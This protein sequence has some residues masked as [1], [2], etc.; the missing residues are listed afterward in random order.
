MKNDYIR[1]KYENNQIWRRQPF[2]RTYLLRLL[3]FSLILGALPTLF[4]G[5]ASY[6]IATRGMEEKVNEGSMHLLLQT[7]LR[8]EQML[9]SLE[10]STT[11]FVNSSLLKSTLDRALTSQDFIQVRGLQAELT[12]LQSTAVVKQAHLVNFS[13]DWVLN[14]LALK[15]LSTSEEAD[16]FRTYAGQS[17]G[18]AWNTRIR[19]ATDT[20][21]AGEAGADL[22][23]A[24]VETISLIYKIPLIPPG[25]PSKALLVVQISSND[26]RSVLTHSETLGVHYIL[27]PAG[28]PFLSSRSDAEAYRNINSAI[29]RRVQELGQA[30]GF[31]YAEVNDRKV[32]VMYRTSGYNGWT[33]VSVVSHEAITR[34]TKTIG[35]FTA[36]VCGVILLIVLVLAYFG[37]RKMYSPIRSLLVY[38]EEIGEDGEPERGR[39]DELAFIKQRIES[40]AVSKTNLK[41]LMQGQA[42]SLK[43]FCVLKLF[44]GQMSDNEFAFRTASY[45]FPTEWNQLGVLT[46]QIDSLRNTRYKGQDRELLLFAINNIVDELLPAQTRFSPILL[47]E[48]QITLL[49]S[50]TEDVQELRS[51]FYRTAEQIK[52]TVEQ[53]LQLTVSI[54]ISRPFT[55]LSESP[56]AYGECLE[57]LK[58]RISLGP[59]IIVHYEDS[60]SKGTGETVVYSHLKLIEE[61]IIQSLREVHLQRVNGLF[62]QYLDAVLNKE[63]YAQEHRILLVQ[64][65]SRILQIVQ[66]QGISVRKVVEGEA[67]VERL[68]RMQT[69]EEIS[70]W[71]EARLFAPV[72]G[73][74]ADKSETQ[75]INIADRMLAMIHEQYDQDLTLELCAG[76]LNFHPVYLSRVFKREVGLPFSDYLSEYRMKMAKLMLET[77]SMKISEIS[78]KLQY[79]NNS[80]FIRN[81]RRLFGVTPGQYREN[82]QNDRRPPE[83]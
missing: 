34:E 16:T 30:Q 83:S 61:Q 7:Q 70:L 22:P 14:L 21:A 82:L 3:I 57:A 43:E 45:G 28:N 13:H 29:G 77:T 78:D 11:Q 80:S 48:S 39:K 37:S 62:Q 8:V 66:E 54:G 65:V 64:L 5:A 81:F 6:Y 53:Y 68:L 12:H 19:L 20:A 79:K 23:G 52:S 75:Y 63:L 49:A 26:I 17:D 36:A 67:V 74:L 24:P 69:R 41:Q 58:S 44:T 33:Y 15:P 32:G 31:F 10:K 71:F 42:G 56:L 2:V 25:S 1:G 72:I 38:T 73:L 9:Q 40:L 59:D 47:N 27:D 76:T 55:Q 4:I 46:L 35:I 51:F 60:V 18:I 50:Q